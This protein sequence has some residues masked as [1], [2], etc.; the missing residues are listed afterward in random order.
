MWVAYVGFDLSSTIIKFLKFGTVGLSGVIINLIVFY[1]SFNQ[2]GLSLNLSS[3]TAFFFASMNNYLWGH[4]WA[5]ATPQMELQ[6]SF[7]N[8]LNSNSAH[9]TKL[10]RKEIRTSFLD[11]RG[12]GK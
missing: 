10:C 5:F 9:K 8:Y 12:S 7:T 3:V 2:F 4:Y 1:L 11:I 6:L